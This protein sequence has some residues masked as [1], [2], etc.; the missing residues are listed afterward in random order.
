MQST[1]F[2][3]QNEAMQYLFNCANSQSFSDQAKPFLYKTL[4]IT[5]SG[6]KAAKEKETKIKKEEKENMRSGSGLYVAGFCFIF[7]ALILYIVSVS[8]A[9]GV[10]N[11]QT[12][13]F[14]AAAFVVGS[15]CFVGA[16]IIKA[17][18]TVYTDP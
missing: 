16:R 18:K 17:W 11:I 4:G 15:L 3:K 7:L 8:N 2:N 1:D 5:D 9:Y 14:S 6:I 13:V 10:A 12:T